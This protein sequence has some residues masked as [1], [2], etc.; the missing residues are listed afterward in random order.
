MPGLLYIRY[1]TVLA[2]RALA[3]KHKRGEEALATVLVHTSTS[4]LVTSLHRIRPRLRSCCAQR[5]IVAFSGL[6]V[7][8]PSTLTA[9]ARR[10]LSGRAH[11]GM[12]PPIDLL[13]GSGCRPIRRRAR[14]HSSCRAGSTRARR[15]RPS[16]RRRASRLARWCSRWSVGGPLLLAF[17]ARSRAEARPA[18]NG[19]AQPGAVVRT[20]EDSEEE[21]EEAEEL[22]VSKRVELD[23]DDGEVI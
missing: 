9:A 14:A 21:E 7:Q 6:R 8:G 1:G 5:S 12:R 16:R 20:S 15:R 11:T 3:A 17:G 2:A 22:V 13:F 19:A 4:P 10:G 23:M 18:R